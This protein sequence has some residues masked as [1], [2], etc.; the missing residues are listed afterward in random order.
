MTIRSIDPGSAQL[1]GREAVR[2]ADD[3]WDVR[4][5][6]RV[7]DIEQMTWG[8]T[9]E[10]PPLD[11]T[12]FIGVVDCET[13][14]LDALTASVIDVALCVLEVGPDGQIV[15]L[16]ECRQ[17]LRDPGM[18]IPM[19]ITRL[20]GI[21]NADVAGAR[22]DADDWTNVLNRCDMLVA[23]NAAY[24]AVVLERLLPGIR[25]K[26]WACSMREIDWPGIGFDSRVLGY[27]LTQIDLFNKGHRA[28][29]DVTSLV[30]L[31]AWQAPDGRCLMAHLL[32]SADRTTVRVEALRARYSKKGLLK[33]RGYRWDPVKTVWWKEVAEDAAEAETHWLSFEAECSSALEK[34]TAAQRYR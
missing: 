26:R 16:A 31:L 9:G 33:E 29:A 25:G 22:F 17:A 8:Q 13:T 34:V 3:S 12:R 5:L 6:R 14:A 21:C 7:C 28:M 24:D 19:E 15:G 32:Q 27:L 18:A 11:Q 1:P 30:H 4:I 23:H 20:T 2:E 10:R